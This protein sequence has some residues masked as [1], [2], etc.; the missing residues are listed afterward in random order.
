MW[1]REPSGAS[2]WNRVLCSRT[3]VSRRTG[4]FTRPK[5]TEPFQIDRATTSPFSYAL[6]RFLAAVFLAARFFVA[7]FFVAAFFFVGAFF[8]VALVAFFFAGA[9][10]PWHNSRQ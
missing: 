4:M 2:W 5:L 1:I 8:F 7:A 9:F 6:A 3:A 10:V